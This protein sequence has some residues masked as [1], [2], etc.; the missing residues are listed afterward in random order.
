V[1]DSDAKII[2]TDIERLQVVL[3]VAQELGI[4]KDSVILLGND[5][6]AASKAGHKCLGD[7][8]ACG[9]LDWE[10]LDKQSDL[11]NRSGELGILMATRADSKHLTD[12]P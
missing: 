8:I 9:E 4:P 12:W 2:L 1:R 3:N 11:T 5:G 6:E 10:R 7:L